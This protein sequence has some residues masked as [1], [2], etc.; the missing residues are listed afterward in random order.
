MSFW[1]QFWLTSDN[2]VV[3]NLEIIGEAA[4]TYSRSAL[5]TSGYWVAEDSWFTRYPLPHLLQ[6]KEAILW[7]AEWSAAAGA[8][9]GLA[10]LEN[11]KLIL[12]SIKGAT[13]HTA[14]SQMDGNI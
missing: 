12:Y 10:D 6:G 9:K 4:K 3:R 1:R 7:R 5:A 14:N 8:E 11:F 2:D 13:K